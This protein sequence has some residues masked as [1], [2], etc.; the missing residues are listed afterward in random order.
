MVSWW[1][2]LVSG[3]IKI[4]VEVNNKGVSGRERVMRD[5]WSRQSYV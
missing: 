3:N 5:K 1:K 4:K 2:K